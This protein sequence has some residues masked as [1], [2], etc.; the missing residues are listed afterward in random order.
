MNDSSLSVA[1]AAALATAILAGPGIVAAIVLRARLLPAVA[2]ASTG[3]IAG[4]SLV[5]VVAELVHLPFGAWVLLPV[6]ALAALLIA[7]G[8][9]RWRTSRERRLPLLLVWVGAVAVIAVV[10]ASAAGPGTLSLTYDG[11]FHLNAVARILDEG[12]ASSFTLYQLTNPGDEVEFYPAAWHALVALVAGTGISIP[13]A[14]SGVWIA[15]AAAVWLP[16]IAWLAATVL[17]EP[18]REAGTLVALALGGVSAGFPYLLLEWGTLYPTGLAYA[19]LPVGVVLLLRLLRIVPATRRRSMDVGLALVWALAAAFAHPRS[20]VTFAVIA[21]PIVA[22]AVVLALVRLAR[23]PRGRILVTSV[24]IALAAVTAASVTVGSIFI[25]RY[26]GADVRP[27]SDR[28]NGGPARANQTVLDAIGQV[29]G[30]APVLSPTQAAAPAALGVAVLVIIG[31]V[32]AA[33]RP[34]TL[35]ITVSFVIL[36]LLYVVAASSD[37]DLA[38]IMTGLWYKD[39]FRLAAALP[40]VAIPAAAMAATTMVEAVRRRF[41]GTGAQRAIVAVG[42]VAIL[43]TAVPGLVATSDALSRVF[44]IPDVKSGALLDR[45][46]YAL[47]ERLPEALPA[48]AVVVGNPWNG[49]AL[50]WALGGRRALFPH[51]AGYWD[52]DRILIAQSLDTASTDPAVCA[53]IDRLG[54]THLLASEGLMGGGDATSAFYAGLDRAANAPGFTEIDREGGTVLYRIDA[55]D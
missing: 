12:D 52:A 29:L 1:A 36:G 37:S 53:A 54:V 32:V 55:C 24:V 48:D 26:F 6:G 50:S 19:L 46:E 49:S 34:R 8:R 13:A 9:S 47:L 5:A 2:L 7:L 40:I 11:V 42:G 31:L 20:L 17:P 39:K 27:I 3:V 41:A 45:D 28:L 33:R 43:A 22:T 21:A 51:I 30:Q 38:K 4:I 14:T 44:T 23:R 10:T 18:R 15:V 16:G 25:L 35:W